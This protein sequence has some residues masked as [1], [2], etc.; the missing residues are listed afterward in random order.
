MFIF[1]FAFY[2]HFY[3]LHSLFLSC[4]RLCCLL[5]NIR[6]TEFSL[7]DPIKIWSSPELHFNWL[8]NKPIEISQ[9]WFSSTVSINIFGGISLQLMIRSWPDTIAGRGR[10]AINEQGIPAS[11]PCLTFVQLSSWRISQIKQSIQLPRNTFC[12]YFPLD[13]YRRGTRA[14]LIFLGA[15]LLL[16]VF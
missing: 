8:R 6:Q 16:S 12:P 7:K 11:G 5:L 3:F 13:L 14:V 10:S 4:A 2:F 15:T 9:S 1:T